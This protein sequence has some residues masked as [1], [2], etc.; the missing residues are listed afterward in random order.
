MS[1]ATLFDGGRGN[2]RRRPFADLLGRDEEPAAAPHLMPAVGRAEGP[3]ADD[4][5]WLEEAV[6]RTA[7]ERCRETLGTVKPAEL[8]ALAD[9]AA[10][11]KARYLAMALDMGEGDALPEA[12][13][14]EALDHARKR[15]EA[16]Q[17]ALDALTDA[18]GRGQ[19]RVAT[20]ARPVAPAQSEG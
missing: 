11:A 4:P 18:L 20:I 16:M 7:R 10:K 5:A 2:Q 15:H 8:Q 3:R 6:R 14:I 17:T 19:M 1:A 9:K 12:K 13:Q